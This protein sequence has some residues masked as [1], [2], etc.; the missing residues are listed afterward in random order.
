MSNPTASIIMAAYNHAEYIG[1]AIDSILAQ[2]WQD[3]ELVVVDDGS[4]DR[5]KEIVSRYGEPIHYVY[6]ENQGQGGARN[7]GIAH[8]R[9]KYVCFLDDDDLWLPNYLQ[10]VMS[11]LEARP[12]VGALYAACQMIDSSGNRLPQTISRVVPPE[13]MYDTLVEG[14]WFP[15]L[16]VTVRKAVLD[17]VGPLD[18]SLRGTDDWELWLRVARQHVFLG[19]PDV[20]ALYRIH[21]G[22]LS[23]NVEHMLCDK[24][25]ALAKHFGPDKGS[26]ATWPAIQRRAY[27]SAYRL[28]A[29]ACLES[30]NVADG[31]SH[32]RRAFEYYPQFAERLDL[33]YELACGLQPRG[34]RG[35]FASHHL[36]ESEQLVWDMLQGVFDAPSASPELSRL[37]RRAWANAHLALGMLA[38][39]SERMRES[40]RHMVQAVQIAPSFATDGRLVSRY[41]KSLLGGRAWH[42][43]RRWRAEYW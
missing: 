21:E 11:V 12:E 39:G 4:V 20:V 40:R 32:L 23:A 19:I 6:Q 38:Y 34:F 22:G 28:A 14:G 29:L 16:V 10:T 8:A 1:A 3:Y 2:T 17:A 26:L 41:V 30:H 15:P 18:V 36:E 5:T 42:A 37:R 24:K 43:L 27:G 33:F 25:R 7:T 9:G 31:Q 35:H 13:R